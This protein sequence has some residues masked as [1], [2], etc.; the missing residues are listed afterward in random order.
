MFSSI[1]RQHG[2]VCDFRLGPLRAALVTHPD[3]VEAVLL[4]RNGAFE[5]GSFAISILGPL[6]GNATSMLEGEIWAGHRRQV[7]PSF[8]RERHKEYLDETLEVVESFAMQWAAA[9]SVRVD[10]EGMRLWMSVMG[11]VLSG[12]DLASEADRILDP[13][14]DA[15]GGVGVSMKLGVSL[16]LWLPLPHLRAIRRGR[17]HLRQLG[18]RLVQE[19]QCSNA[20]SERL[21]GRLATTADTPDGYLRA[22]DDVAGNIA[23]GGHQ[24]MTAFAWTLLCLTEHPQLQEELRDEIRKSEG[25][26]VE[27][28]NVQLLQWAVR[29]SLRLYPPFYAIPRTAARPVEFRGFEVSA[30]TV[31]FT[32]PWVTQRSADYFTDPY[33]YRPKRWQSETGDLPRF[34]YF[35]FGGGG[36]ACIAEKIIPPMLAVAVG[37]LLKNHRIVRLGHEPIEP[38][39]KLS[40]SMSRPLTIR[41]TEASSS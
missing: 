37:A 40:L 19:H 26:A 5:R 8:A 16:P 12:R 39:A 7:A 32:S 14:R 3:D 30:G 9:P 4:N 33:A 17:D 13:V 11:R 35:P 22:R 27:L 10:D 1:A 28:A 29:E 41:L 25:D 15:L 24:M 38:R 34:A 36:H 20:N 31:V 21:L 6:I 18:D 23:V 2:P